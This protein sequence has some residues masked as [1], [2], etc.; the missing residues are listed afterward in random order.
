MNIIIVEAKG[1]PVMK[2]N[3]YIEIFMDNEDLDL[4]TLS[5]FGKNPV[6]NS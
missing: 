5:M 4:K 3:S 2:G 1:L 6:W